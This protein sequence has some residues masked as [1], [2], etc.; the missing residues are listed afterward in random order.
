MKKIRLKAAPEDFKNILSL[1]RLVD[2]SH[3][4]D[5]KSATESDGL[6]ATQDCEKPTKVQRRGEM[7][8][9]TGIYP[10]DITAGGRTMLVY[11]DL[12]EKTL[13]DT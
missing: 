6:N 10:V 12:V 2:R 3:T 1:G 13:G 8:K 4:N 9:Q 11:C 7:T 5:D